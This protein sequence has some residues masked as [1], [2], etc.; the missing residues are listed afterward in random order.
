M[1]DRTK[2]LA[3]RRGQPMADRLVSAGLS[4]YM[5]RS[6]RKM[7][8]ALKRALHPTAARKRVGLESN[9]ATV[10]QEQRWP[11]A[12][13]VGQGYFR[14]WNPILPN[15]RSRPAVALSCLS[16]LSR[17]H[18]QRFQPEA[19]LYNITAPTG[20]SAVHESM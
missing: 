4:K 8:R 3:W 19:L 1:P 7:R 13:Y 5:A 12:W 11:R 10:R 15:A 9:P 6:A 14:G 18:C 20:P 17:C 2:T 16:H